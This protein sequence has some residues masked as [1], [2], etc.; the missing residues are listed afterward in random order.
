MYFSEMFSFPF[1]F[2]SGEQY[3]LD[4]AGNIKKGPTG[5]GSTC[6]CAPFIHRFEQKLDKNKKEIVK[7]LENKHGKLANRINY[8]ER[9]TRDQISGMSNNIK[10]N[11]AQ[12]LFQYFFSREN[13]GMSENKNKNL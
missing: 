12:V 8:L 2:Q 10:E 6:Y 13:K 5:H 3:F 11:L 7:H 1:F 9:K 4:L